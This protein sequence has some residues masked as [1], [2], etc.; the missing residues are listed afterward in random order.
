[1][2][3]STIANL[4][5]L[6]KRVYADK[7][8]DSAMRKHL[9][10]NKLRKEGGFTGEAFFYPIRTTNPQGIAST[11][12]SAQAAVSGSKGYQLQASRKKKYGYITLDGEAMAA[13][14]NDAGA[15]K[16]LVTTETDGVLEEFVDSLAFDAFRDGNGVRGVRGSISSNTITLATRDDA[17]N[18]KINMALASGPNADGSSLNT[19]TGTITVTGVDEDLGT[20][21]V[22]SAANM[23]SFA[24]AHYLFRLGDTGGVCM[25]GLAAH[26]PLTTPG[27]G[28]S[29]R[30]INRS[31][32]P[33]QLAGSRVDDSTLSVEEVIRLLATKISQ[34]GKKADMA[35]MNPIKF[36]EMVR[37]TNA[38]TIY[39]GGGDSAT[40]GFENIKI[41][42]AAGTVSVF[43]DADCPTNRTYVLNTSTLYIKHL[44][45]LPH[46]VDDD[47]KVNLRLAAEDSIEARVRAW[48]NMICT[49]PAANGVGAVY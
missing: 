13:A 5:W 39:D 38:K 10:F 27:G 36:E 34:R 33:H 31:V 23:G 44:Q 45:G 42:T 40:I 8:G 46:L 20:V 26:F 3:A 1:M 47:G 22:S 37:R 24:D 32:A 48:S 12:A 30:G 15:F 25:E 7:V 9:L 16:R 11:F 2:A 41:A 14:S 6:Y 35:V 29:F 4:Q 49:D 18:F 21:T 17:R 43:P 28:D 19:H